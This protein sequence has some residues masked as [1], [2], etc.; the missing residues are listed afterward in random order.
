MHSLSLLYTRVPKTQLLIWGNIRITRQIWGICCDRP[1]NRAQI[2]SKS[3]KSYI[4]P[5]VWPWNLIDDRQMDRTIQRAVWSQLKILNIEL[6]TYMNWRCEL[7]VWSKG[8][9]FPSCWYPN[10]SRI[11][12]WV[13]STTA[14]IYQSSLHK[15][16]FFP[17]HSAHSLGSGDAIWWQR[18]GTT[19]AQ[20]MAWCL[21]AP[22][23]YLNQ[24]WLI[25]SKVQWHS[26]DGNFIRDTSASNHKM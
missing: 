10:I 20:V 1:S 14:G 7:L 26:S 2:I 4:F 22:S 23:H 12:S 11:Y 5:S 9:T 17:Y 15:C 25:I 16:M 8:F 18:S 3:M 21:T 24:C 6:L 19:L 13:S